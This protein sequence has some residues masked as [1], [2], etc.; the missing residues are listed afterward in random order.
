MPS[1]LPWGTDCSHFLETILS[2][3]WLLPSVDC[4]DVFAAHERQDCLD[5][6]RE[7]HNVVVEY[8]R[9]DTVDGMASGFAHAEA[10]VKDDESAAARMKG[11]DKAVAFADRE[12]NAV[13]VE[14]VARADDLKDAGMD[15]QPLGNSWGPVASAEAGSI[16]VGF[17]MELKSALEGSRQAGSADRKAKR[18]RT[19]KID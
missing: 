13:V 5:F 9:S 15:A 2:A 4:R 18:I 11:I 19:G 17:A 16:G 14:H 3:Q 8:S 1:P 6:V 12:D 10:R 7:T